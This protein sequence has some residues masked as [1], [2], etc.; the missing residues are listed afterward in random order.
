MNHNL[1]QPP[2]VISAHQLAFGY[3][4]SLVLEDVN[5]SVKKGEFLGIFGPNGGGK[6]TLLKLIMGFLESTSGR[7]EVFGKLPRSSQQKISYVPQSL[8]FDRKFPISVL[9]LILSGRLAHLPWYGRY[10]KEDRQKALE[11]LEK[12][13]LVDMKERAFGTLS[14]GQAQRALIARALVSEPELLLLDEPTASVDT[15]AETEIYTLLE[16]L[17]GKMTILMVTHHLRTAI[18]QVQRVLCVKKNVISLQPEEVCEHFAIGLYH[19]P[20]EGV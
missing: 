10:H 2:F 12:V 13:G 18:N 17:K 3:Q 8:H 1:T 4:D 14:G 5:F 19:P 9:E 11:V 15:H 7:I 20:L 6:T 16:G